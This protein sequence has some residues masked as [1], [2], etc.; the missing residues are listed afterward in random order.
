[1]MLSTGAST[2]DWF[3]VHRKA[4]DSAIDDRMACYPAADLLL[5][6]A[7]QYACSGGGKRL[8]A[9]LVLGTAQAVGAGVAQAMPAACAVEALHA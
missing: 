2:V 5:R 1:M 4:V 6:D 3:A 7:M 9:L 8:R